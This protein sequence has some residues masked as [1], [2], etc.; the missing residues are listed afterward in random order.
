VEIRKSLMNNKNKGLIKFVIYGEN[1]TDR[2]HETKNF[3]QKYPGIAD[4]SDFKR[5]N[6]GITII[7]K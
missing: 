4:D 3:I 1:F 5:G 6:K 2:D 7:A